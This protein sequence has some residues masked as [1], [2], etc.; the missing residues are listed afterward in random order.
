MQDAAAH[1]AARPKGDTVDQDALARRPQTDLQIRIASANKELR[2]LGH[3]AG[4][5]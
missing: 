5:P 2:R 1:A 4:R 3:P